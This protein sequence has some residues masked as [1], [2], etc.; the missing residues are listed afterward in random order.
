MLLTL[1]VL[2]IG[3]PW[4]GKLRGAALVSLLGLIGL[5]A[6]T[7]ISAIWSP[8]PDIEIGDTQRAI[9]YVVAMVLGIWAALLL[10]R[11]R[12]LALMPIAVAGALVGIAVGNLEDGRAVQLTLRTQAT[13]VLPSGFRVRLEKQ[14]GG[15]SWRLVGTRPRGTLCH[16]PCTVSGGGKSEISKSISNALLQGPVFVRDYHRDMDQVA[17]IFAR[18]GESYF[19]S[20]EARVIARLL[21]QGPQVLAT[22]GGAFMNGETRASISQKGISVW[23][24]ADFEVLMRRVKRRSGDRPMLQGDPAE[25]VRHLMEERYPV[26]GEADTMVMSR[27]VPHETIVNEIVAALAGKL[28]VAVPAPITVAEAT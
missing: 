16:K 13:Y 7:L 28:N 19:R 25:R 11:R 15:S 26:Y 18:D 14:P 1:G 5:A 23:L 17:E 8:T 20:G 22:G 21:D 9:A 6:W 27:D 12:M 24:K 3:A 2:L 10:G 4:P